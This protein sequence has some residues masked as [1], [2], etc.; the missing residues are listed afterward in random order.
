MR[1]LTWHAVNVKVDIS[2]VNKVFL[3]YNAVKSWLM[4]LQID[5]KFVTDIIFQVLLANG[6][7]LEDLSP[8]AWESS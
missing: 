8:Q 1:P 6:R 4:L 3:F 5:I 7:W 2:L